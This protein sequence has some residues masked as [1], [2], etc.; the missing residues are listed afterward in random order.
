[1]VY[2]YNEIRK[3]KLLGTA[4][5][6]LKQLEEDSERENV[7]LP[8]V[9]N[10]KT[11]GEVVFDVRYYPVLRPT[12]LEDG[13]E[14]PPPETSTGIVA[15]TVHQAKDLDTKKSLTG[16][17]SPYAV[18]SLNGKEIYSTKKMKRTLNPV[19]DEH[20]EML[21]HNRLN[22]RLGVTIKDDRDF[23]GAVTVG[24][25]QIRL[26]DFLERMDAQQDWFTLSG[27]PTGKVRM[28]VKWKPVNMPGGVQ[29]SGGY[30]TPI[31]VMRF[32]FKQAKDVRNVEAV[33]GGKSD[34]YVRVTISNFE[35]A[36]TVHIN[37]DL[38]PVWNEILYVPVHHTKEQYILEVM[39]YQ[40]HGKDRSLGYTQINAADLVH[41]NDLGE[42]L[43]LSDDKTRVEP[44][45]ND[46]KE[47]KGFLHY[48]VSFYPCLNVADPEEEEEEQKN[49]IQELPDGPTKSETSVTPQ[50]VPS[51]SKP[52][53][54]G[55]PNIAKDP[56]K[57]D[58]SPKPKQNS[59]IG[60]QPAAQRSSVS[61]DSV[62]HQSSGSISSVREKKEPPKIHLSPEQLVKYNSGV[63]IFKIIEAQLAHKDCF[64]EVLFDDYAFPSYV[65]TKARSRHQ[66]WDEIGDG[67]VRELEF[68]RITLRL[69]SRVDQQSKVDESDIIASLSGD[70]LDVLKTSLNNPHEYT[71]KSQS[72]ELYKIKISTKYIPVEYELDPSESINNMGDL[73][74]DVVEA[75]NLPAAD[76][77]G[78]SDP[79]CVFI[80]NGEKVFKTK[81]IKKTLNPTWDEKFDVS[82][83][84]RTAADFEVEVYDWDFAGGDDF[85][86]KA[87]IFLTEIEPFQQKTMS[88]PLEGKSGEIKL[89]FL[90]KPAYI[91]RSR[92]GTSTFTAGRVVTGLAGAP[93]KVVGGG[94]QG[95]SKGLGAAAGGLGG[96]AGFVKRGFIKKKVD[97]DA[98]DEDIGPREVAIAKAAVAS[99]GGIKGTSDGVQLAVT[100]DSKETPLN[101]EPEELQSNGPAATPPSRGSSGPGHVRDISIASSKIGVESGLLQIA[102]VEG[103]GFPQGKEIR[104]VLRTPQKE[105]YKSKAV[106]AS[107]PSWYIPL[108]SS[109]LTWDVGTRVTRSLS[110]PV[111][112]LLFQLLITIHLAQ[113]RTLEKRHLLSKSTALVI[114]GLTLAEMRR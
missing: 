91:S 5:F 95:V 16:S 98:Q 6:D 1:M 74:V 90:F 106:K 10:A 9:Y 67:F 51:T 7:T 108:Y 41:Q 31:G 76:R 63:L 104:I 22:C 66:K 64:V 24:G 89:K 65:S 40:S 60:S 84:S 27:A 105:F 68:S 58:S 71:L 54:P 42:Y 73:R 114:S 88:L 52:A 107:D 86:G 36:R 8:V 56:A 13:T 62:G 80:L 99:G 19:W 81:V 20:V 79:Y 18:M 83:P 32:N 26:N 53:T 4:N 25:Y 93:V 47:A 34:P 14:Q 100:G 77:T 12:K 61:M 59:T 110:R 109:E 44:L 94:V 29:G 21:V 92:R 2:D 96:A 85:L 17:L 33:T 50:K 70:T 82:V 43:E 15:F 38:N 78:Y 11:R 101:A 46:K 75:K 35:K 112:K 39:D 69:R 111:N 55:T 57:P 113:I 102:V 87:H 49:K 37:N 97:P 23:G 45:K 28:E 3:D 30:I 103:K 48:S 72:G